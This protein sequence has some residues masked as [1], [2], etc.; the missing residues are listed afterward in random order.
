MSFAN[1]I[2]S[3]SKYIPCVEAPKEKPALAQR[4]KYSFFAIVIFVIFLLLEWHQVL[5]L[6]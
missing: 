6:N 5:H 4:L 1:V 2:S 3:I